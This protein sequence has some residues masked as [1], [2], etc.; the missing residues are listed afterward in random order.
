MFGSL[1]FGEI[2]LIGLVALIVFGP[3]RLP[4]IARKVGELMTKARSATQELT[5]ALDAEYQ[6]TTKPLT[7]L[8]SEYDATKQQLT[9]TA[10]KLTDMAASPPPTDQPPDDEN[11]QSGGDEEPT[12]R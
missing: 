6:G 8:K 9:D 10:S 2:L 5:D 3:Q 11:G 1:G 4:E 12:S 7:D